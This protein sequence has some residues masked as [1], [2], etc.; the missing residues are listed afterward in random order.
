MPPRCC[1]VDPLRDDY[2]LEIE[3]RLPE[4]VVAGMI[5][6]GIQIRPLPMYDYNMAHFKSAGVIWPAAGRRQRHPRRAGTAS[7]DQA[8]EGHQMADRKIRWGVISPANIGRAAVI[9]AIQAS[10]KGELAAVAGR[11]A[12]KA[13]AFAAQLVI[14][15]AYGSYAALLEA[16]DIDA[17]YIPLPKSLIANGPCG[18]PRWANT[19]CARN[20][21]V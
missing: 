10:R 4:Q 17:V 20:R 1:R 11:E 15:K 2:V 7:G 6:L 18:Q 5:K 14:T 8:G 13:E 12:G 3:S 19:S 9:P 21:W 16:P